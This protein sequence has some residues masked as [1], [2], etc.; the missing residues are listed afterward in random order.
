M[1]KELGK[2]FT[3][4]EVDRA[5][6]SINYSDFNE[7][8]LQFPYSHDKSLRIASL[9]ICDAFLHLTVNNI[10][11]ES[12]TCWYKKLHPKSAFGGESVYFHQESRFVISWGYDPSATRS[13]SIR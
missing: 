1:I 7:Q 10:L 11:G 2:V 8:A 6:E 5:L 9:D 3:D 12:Y 13:V 4:E